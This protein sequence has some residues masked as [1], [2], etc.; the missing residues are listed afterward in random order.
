MLVF[1]AV[2]RMCCSS[3]IHFKRMTLMDHCGEKSQSLGGTWGGR[4]EDHASA[5]V[6][7]NFHCKKLATNSIRSPEMFHLHMTLGI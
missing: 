1:K 4:C 6:S 7:Q 2:H 3:G 5:R